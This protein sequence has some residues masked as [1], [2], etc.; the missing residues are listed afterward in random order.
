MSKVLRTHGPIAA[1]RKWLQETEDAKYWISNSQTMRQFIFRVGNG[2]GLSYELTAAPKGRV[3]VWTVDDH[4][5]S[6]LNSHLYRRITEVEASVY[7][8]QAYGVSTVEEN[9]KFDQFLQGKAHY[10]EKLV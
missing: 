7:H 10:A 9:T 3:V 8:T 4:A 1:L 6:G 2:K 5:L